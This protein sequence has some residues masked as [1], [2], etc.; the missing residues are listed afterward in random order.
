MIKDFTLLSSDYA[1]GSVNT[2]ALADRAVTPIK[3]D[4][5]AVTTPKLADNAVT[6]AKVADGSLV[7]ADLGAASTTI[8]DPPSIPANSCAVVN[9]AA[10]GVP[11]N[12]RLILNVPSDLDPGLFFSGA[13]TG[14]AADTISARVCNVTGSGIDDVAKSWSYLAVR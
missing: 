2:A 10:S 7:A 8:V 11:A 1:P 6:S 5:L 9:A 3:L 4:D 12:A 14:N 13:V